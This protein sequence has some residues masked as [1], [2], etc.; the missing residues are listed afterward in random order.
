MAL[1][2]SVESLSIMTVSFKVELADGTF[3]VAPMDIVANIQLESGMKLHLKAVRDSTGV[4]LTLS[5]SNHLGSRLNE[6]TLDAEFVFPPGTF[7]SLFELPDSLDYSLLN[8]EHEITALPSILNCEY[9]SIPILM[10]PIISVVLQ[11]T[12]QSR[13]RAHSQSSPVLTHRRRVGHRLANPRCFTHPILH[14]HART[15]E[16]CRAT[17][18]QVSQISQIVP[19]HYDL[20]DWCLT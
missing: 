14:R 3:E 19:L 11:G 2:L 18:A 15:I 1:T 9:R 13:R 6:E 5:A 10:C 4:T 12:V 7:D 16:E 20:H 8:F 17:P